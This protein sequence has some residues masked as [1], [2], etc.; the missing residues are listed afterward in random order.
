MVIVE[1]AGGGEK[2]EHEGKSQIEMKCRGFSRKDMP[3]P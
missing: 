1:E 2:C 3:L